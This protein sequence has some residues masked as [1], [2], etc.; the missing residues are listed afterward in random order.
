MQLPQTT[1][2]RHCR[3]FHYARLLA[4]W[5]RNSNQ[6]NTAGHTKVWIIQ[7]NKENVITE[8]KVN[9]RH[10]DR[11][12]VEDIEKMTDFDDHHVGVFSTDFMFQL[13]K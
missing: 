13:T 1:Q 3:Y 9:C 5:S 2:Y 10:D 8:I 6:R 7:Y 12:Q 4:Q 11:G